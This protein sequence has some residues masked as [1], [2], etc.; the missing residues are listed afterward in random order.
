MTDRDIKALQREIEE[1]RRSISREQDAIEKAVEATVARVEKLRAVIAQK[2][3]LL[4]PATVLS[5]SAPIQ[6]HEKPPYIPWEEG[7][8]IT[9][10]MDAPFAVQPVP[11]ARRGRP[12]K[13]K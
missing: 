5:P 12:P 3:A 2:E 9:F 7:M 4:S 10:P 13:T 11:T 6:L 1:H 8:N